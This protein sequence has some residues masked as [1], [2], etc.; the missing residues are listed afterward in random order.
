MSK[1]NIVHSQRITTA[2][3]AVP[4]TFTR[5]SWI[6]NFFITSTPLGA[7]NIVIS[8]S[9]CLFVCSLAYLKTTVRISPI[10]FCTCY[11]WS[12]LGPPLTC[13]AIHYIL[14]VVCMTSCF[15]VIKKS[16]TASQRHCCSEL[17]FHLVR[18]QPGR[19]SLSTKFLDRLL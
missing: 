12:W 2:V 10:F 16:I 17:Q 11:L 18:N 1:Q 3:H 9:V 7:Q 13:C 14:P 19:C 4:V 5:C 8:V 6:P 15:H